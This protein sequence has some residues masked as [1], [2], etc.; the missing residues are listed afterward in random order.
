MRG[1][2]LGPGSE[3]EAG[4]NCASRKTANW[5]QP[6]AATG[7]KC[8]CWSEEAGLGHPQEQEANRLQTERNKPH[9]PLPAS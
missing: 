6:A 9:L 4:W 8:S 2:G 5:I 1:R 3:E 7:R